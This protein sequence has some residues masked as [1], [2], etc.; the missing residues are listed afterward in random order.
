[1]LPL[2]G[3]YFLEHKSEDISLDGLEE[4]LEEHKNYDVSA[5]L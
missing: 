2:I 5:L 1:M 4:E 3:I